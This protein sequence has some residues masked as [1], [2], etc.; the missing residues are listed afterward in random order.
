MRMIKRLLLKCACGKKIPDSIIDNVC[1][2]IED[3]IQELIEDEE[4]KLE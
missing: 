4:E 2:I 1:D 3:I